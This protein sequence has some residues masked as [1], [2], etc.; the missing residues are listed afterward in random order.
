MLCYVANMPIPVSKAKRAVKPAETVETAPKSL[1]EADVRVGEK[2]VEPP[3]APKPMEAVAPEP[4]PIRVPEPAKPVEPALREPK[5]V[6]VPT[7][8]VKAAKPEPA[9]ELKTPSEPVP[10]AEPP[11]PP[12]QAGYIFTVEDAEELVDRLFE[13]R[14]RGENRAGK[15]LTD[16]AESRN[17][18]MED[19]IKDAARQ[20]FN[21]PQVLMEVNKRPQGLSLAQRAIG[22]IDEDRAATVAKEYADIAKRSMRS[23]GRWPQV[24]AAETPAEG[25]RTREQEQQRLL[26]QGRRE[27]ASI[28]DLST[29]SVK[30]SDKRAGILESGEEGV[31]EEG[32]V[33]EDPEVAQP[34]Q[35][36]YK[37]AES[38]YRMIPEERRKILL[39][40]FQ[41]VSSDK[42]SAVRKIQQHIRDNEWLTIEYGGKKWDVRGG[43][44][45][46]YLA[47]NPR[48]A[49]TVSEMPERL[50][51][52]ARDEIESL[53]DQAAFSR[54]F[55][56]VAA[57]RT[58]GAVPQRVYL[59]VDPTEFS[60]VGLTPGDELPARSRPE[61]IERLV[62]NGRYADALM[63]SLAPTIEI[64]GFTGGR[65]EDTKGQGREI[66]LRKQ[67]RVST[68]MDDLDIVAAM[69]IEY[70][71]RGLVYGM[72]YDLMER[73]DN[74]AELATNAKKLA[75]DFFSS[76]LSRQARRENLM[77]AAA[78]SPEMRKFFEKAVVMAPALDAAGVK[79]PFG[80]DSWSEI[81]GD[82][83]F[84]V[85][86]FVASVGVPD[87][88]DA[89]RLAKYGPDAVR[90][91]QQAAKSGAVGRAV[92]QYTPLRTATTQ[93]DEAVVGA[94]GAAAKLEKAVEAG[95]PTLADDLGALE[96]Q[97]RT[98]ESSRKKKGEFGEDLRAPVI[99][100]APFVR[101]VD[102]VAAAK[103]NK[104]VGEADEVPALADLDAMKNLPELSE[105]S[106]L[107]ATGKKLEIIDRKAGYTEA[108]D[109]LAARQ[110]LQSAG[111]MV[112]PSI[113]RA[114]PGRAME[115]EHRHVYDF[116]TK[117]RN[118]DRMQ[119]M[120][121]GN[122]IYSQKVADAYRQRVEKM[123][124]DAGVPE[125]AAKRTA[126]RA[127]AVLKDSLD[128][129][130]DLGAAS[131]LDKRLSDQL[132]KAS[133]MPKV[134][135][136]TRA[137]YATAANSL[138][139]AADPVEALTSVNEQAKVAGKAAVARAR[140]SLLQSM[141]VR[142]EA[143]REVHD[144]LLKE[145]DLG[146]V[147]DKYVTPSASEAADDADAL[148]D[149]SRPTVRDVAGRG[150][151]VPLRAIDWLSKQAEAA[152][153]P[154]DAE[155]TLRRLR[156]GETVELPF[157]IRG[158]TR[159][160][161]DDLL[162]LQMDLDRIRTV[163]GQA[164]LSVPLKSGRGF[165]EEE[166]TSQAVLSMAS[167]RG[168]VRPGFLSD[169]DKNTFVR[170]VKAF[171]NAFG[172]TVWD[173]VGKRLPQLIIGGDEDAALRMMPPRLREIYRQQ[174]RM[175][176]QRVGDI[177][178]LLTETEPGSWDRVID[179]LAGTRMRFAKSGRPV[180]TS[181]HDALSEIGGAVRR[182]YEALRGEV[183]KI[184]DVT[185]EDL[186]ID[187]SLA[188]LDKRGQPT[189]DINEAI[190]YGDLIDEVGATIMSR[191]ETSGGR[192]RAAKA[193]G[194]SADIV[195]PEAAKAYSNRRAL[196]IAKL[197]GQ[198]A[199]PFFENL[200]ATMFDG[201]K[202]ASQTEGS[203]DQYVYAML[204]LAGGQVG[205]DATGK[206]VIEF[207]DKSS[208]DL[209]RDFFR[210]I[211]DLPSN[212]AKARVAALIGAYGY[213]TTA[214]NKL[215]DLG[216]TLT[217]PEL[218]LLRKI[219]NSQH[220][221]ADE[222]AEALTLLRT[223]GVSTDGLKESQQ[224]LMKSAG[225]G[226]RYLPD[227]AER[228]L[229]QALGLAVDREVRAAMKYGD[230]P[231]MGM[232]ALRVLIQIN[233]LVKNH[234]VRGVMFPKA[235]MVF[236]DI[237][238]GS[239]HLGVYTGD[240]GTTMRYFLRAA[241]QGITMVPGFD[242][243]RRSAQYGA[244]MIAGGMAGLLAESNAL[245]KVGEPPL[246]DFS[247]LKIEDIREA[248]AAGTDGVIRA[249][250]GLSFDLRANQ[251]LRGDSGVFETAD[252]RRYRIED[253]RKAAIESSVLQSFASTELGPV[254]RRQHG[255]LPSG[256]TDAVRHPLATGKWLV[257][258]VAGGYTDSVSE[259]A[260]GF[261]ER[262]R[263]GG[264]LAIAEAGADPYEA[265]R[266]LRQALFDFPGS[267]ADSERISSVTGFAI[268]LLHPFWTYQKNINRRMVDAVADPVVGWR[269]KA[270]M[271]AFEKG[272]DAFND[273]VYNVMFDPYGF[274]TS[275]MTDDERRLYTFFRDRWEDNM[276]RTGNEQTPFERAMFA[277]MLVNTQEASSMS[278][279]VWRRPLAVPQ[280]MVAEAD[281]MMGG[282]LQEYIDMSYPDAVTKE[283]R[284]AKSREA[285]LLAEGLKQRYSKRATTAL[286]KDYERDQINLSIP[287]RRNDA[288]N[289]WVRTTGKADA[290]Y[291][292]SMTPPGIYD[293]F[294]YTSGM[295]MV[296]PEMV[297][298]ILAPE[299]ETM[300]GMGEVLET[301][302]PLD[303]LRSPLTNE[304]MIVLRGGQSVRLPRN[305][306]RFFKSMHSPLVSSLVT[307]GGGVDPGQTEAE[308]VAGVGGDAGAVV[309][310]D[311][312]VAPPL[313]A[314]LIRNVPY[315]AEPFRLARMFDQDRLFGAEG[316]MPGAVPVGL[317]LTGVGKMGVRS[318]E[319]VKRD[320]TY[321][322]RGQMR[323]LNE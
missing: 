106:Y 275:S 112:D 283:A 230:K 269:F 95:D 260:E 232:A 52:E 77:T 59:G 240:T 35:S 195:D 169:D 267:V 245:R 143:Y 197:T 78:E 65:D 278:P 29:L 159:F 152:G 79:A 176:V 212:E 189:G 239:H 178:N 125:K 215:I 88:L 24:S 227:A 293:A 133:D 186:D 311:Y 63:L 41:H 220:L 96:A 228:M 139:N 292:V 39:N 117:S 171:A 209:G 287:A 147:L 217:G 206:F 84:I 163:G 71:D 103:V 307:K 188:Y 114:L 242:L 173:A 15:V 211:E 101:A 126:E 304:I 161:D 91:F 148:V 301:T 60:T 142:A 258:D 185:A 193:V 231:P 297:N 286:Q 43:S 233:Q 310:E 261:S 104:M 162:D 80:A 234:W 250:F 308:Q 196:L 12:K 254:T 92:G 131:A 244:R 107:G 238:E 303:P 175:I 320:A 288:F 113:T 208:V 98:G 110:D 57:A 318:R 251:I 62:D 296:I 280:E 174:E 153:V 172:T 97:L 315:V 290:V 243:G 26:E 226:D 294:N 37:Y 272:D 223:F 263:L 216:A 128:E 124:T 264:M 317:E 204:K 56:E 309:S 130:G 140:E 144:E 70:A 9:P 219:S 257:H 225:Q 42:T 135:E 32:D 68:A 319:D 253:F 155:D 224:I 75:K 276:G 316:Q 222:Y 156:A 150:E 121:D 3:P 23:S 205:K 21:L 149:V 20:N 198:G 218:E 201:Q 83:G 54:T 116:A 252:G 165:V 246:R 192:T 45:R 190:T 123:L 99:A 210:A 72:G 187:K 322:T 19:F 46:D 25:L 89:V 203:L 136:A 312:Y 14:V 141:R 270:S 181:G 247:R 17:V 1:F 214:T 138:R 265:G 279:E 86:G 47:S 164:K 85:T 200:A 183:V 122:Y 168:I 207:V 53:M 221:T 277:S 273:V 10:A 194:S 34:G 16:F 284:D 298:Y 7:R 285:G 289:E 27:V 248:I 28:E 167:D 115:K 237:T 5:S 76:G 146:R 66:L 302:L 102:M 259:L 81:V 249:L 119:E 191:M 118:L 2:P 235:R 321:Q 166:S 184:D 87:P 255:R 111:A 51:V 94:N 55:N 262:A 134:S 145:G 67:T 108:S 61:M 323:P 69:L 31:F 180:S 74:P 266:I 120:L 18:S 157:S 313:M 295:A 11:S 4:K 30:A 199:S 268:N 127:G 160:S 50:Q 282:M 137:A 170:G 13:D 90:S 44:P 129:S 202:L 82:V 158:Q 241:P 132:Q 229:N 299:P 177:N 179:Y 49:K 271:K 58:V 182:E 300:E 33:R 154:F 314:A 73:S 281:R 22:V 38:V 151:A 213:Q 105:G 93:F 291:Q 40:E 306:G 6:D 256:P 305:A 236:L 36:A 100:S 109:E 48:L 8:A 64:I 274:D